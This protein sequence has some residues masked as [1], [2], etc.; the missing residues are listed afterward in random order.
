M[1]DYEEKFHRQGVPIHRCVA[2]RAALP[3]GTVEETAA[4]D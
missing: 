1:T 4:A 2:V 3:E